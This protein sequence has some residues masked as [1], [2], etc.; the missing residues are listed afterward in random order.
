MDSNKKRYELLI[1]FVT[2]IISLGLFKDELA[3]YSIDIGFAAFTAANYFF[4]VVLG[5]GLALYIYVIVYVLKSFRRLQDW[6]SLERIEVIASSIFILV[7]A[8]PFLLL[9]TA[10]LYF[11]GSRVLNLPKEQLAN[12]SSIISLFLTIVTSISTIIL[13]RKVYT[14]RDNERKEYI[15]SEEIIQLDRAAKL[16][17]QEFYSQAILEAFKVLEFHLLKLISDRGIYLAPGR[18]NYSELINYVTKLELL[19]SKELETFKEIRQMRNMAAHADRQH[20]K[21]EATKA[22]E[23]IRYLISK[24]SSD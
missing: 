8:S 22:M 15:E 5:L 23:F 18:F 4:F 11:I 20:T 24:K 7:I 1:G 2:L 9:L 16:Y 17:E 19:N 6:K 10:I 13:T 21:S 14:Q 3:K 12:I